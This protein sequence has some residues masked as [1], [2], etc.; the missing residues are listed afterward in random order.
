MRS[1][2]RYT[3]SR[4]YSHPLVI[5]ISYYYKSLYCHIGQRDYDMR[6]LQLIRHNLIQ[7]FAMRQP[8]ILM[9]HQA[10]NDSQYTIHTIKRIKRTIQL[11]SSV[12][13]MSLPIRKRRIKAMLT[14]PHITGKAF[15]TLRKLKKTEELERNR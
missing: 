10:V 9:K 11:K 1:T 8:D 7:M 14:D 13:M 3:L 4:R 12:S 15:S 5:N 2:V 6:N